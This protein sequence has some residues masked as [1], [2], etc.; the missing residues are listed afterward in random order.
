MRTG[1]TPVCIPQLGWW[2]SFLRMPASAFGSFD[3]LKLST[4]PVGVFRLEALQKQGVSTM[5]RLPFSIRIL[6]ENVLRHAGN[7]VVT[8][9]HVAA[10]GAWK[11]K[12]DQTLEVPFMPARVVLQDFTGVP[13]V[14]D[15]AAMRD[16]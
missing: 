15:L 7:G 8:D 9:R 4:G 6:L 1:A 2:I 10:V 16:A 5:D 12:P 14:V 13:C 11:P 3:T